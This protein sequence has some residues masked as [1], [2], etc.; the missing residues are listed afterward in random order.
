[1]RYRRP[2]SLNKWL[3]RSTSCIIDGRPR[4]ANGVVLL[5]EREK[6]LFVRLGGRF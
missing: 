1:M 4:L 3:R 5:T 6:R 2:F